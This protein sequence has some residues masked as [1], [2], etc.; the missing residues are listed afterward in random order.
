MPTE[1]ADHPRLPSILPVSSKLPQ[2]ND[3]SIGDDAGIYLRIAGT[4]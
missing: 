4:F 2:N 1:D 3:L